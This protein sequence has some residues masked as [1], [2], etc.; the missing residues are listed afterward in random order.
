VRALGDLQRLRPLALNGIAQAVEGAHPGV[1]APGEGEFRGAAGPDHLVM[2]EVRRHADQV[3]VAAL[4][5]D[6]FVAGR[7]GNEVR[8]ALERDTLPVFNVAGDGVLEAQERHGY[9][10]T[11]WD[12]S[13]RYCGR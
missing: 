10:T 3:Q 2:D 6:D 7:E 11:V 12:C 5:P 8:E 13:R 1:A 4:L 9:S